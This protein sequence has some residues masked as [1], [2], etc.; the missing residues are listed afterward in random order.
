MQPGF[1]TLDV[2]ALVFSDHQLTVTIDDVV[3]NFWVA[4]AVGGQ[5]SSGAHA[6]EPTT[7][8]LVGTG[9]VG[10]AGFAGFR[11]RFKR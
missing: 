3:G 1:F 8:L 10:L 2:L 7:L 11:K 9:L 4:M 6:P 5:Y